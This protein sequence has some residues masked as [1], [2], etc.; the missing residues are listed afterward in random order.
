MYIYIYVY[1]V[2]VYI[3]IYTYIDVMGGARESSAVGGSRDREVSQSIMM[4]VSVSTTCIQLC[5]CMCIYIYI[6][7]HAHSTL[8]YA[9]LGHAVQQQKLLAGGALRAY[10]PKGV[11]PRR[12]ALFTDTGN[13]IPRD[14]GNPTG[15]TGGV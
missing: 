5:V 13:N 15:A 2:C 1:C 6:Y 10:L 9:S 7:I 11:L 3:Y 12:S 4:D 8:F 14:V